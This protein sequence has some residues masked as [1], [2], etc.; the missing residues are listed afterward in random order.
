M[1][2][3]LLLIFPAMRMVVCAWGDITISD[4]ARSF[5]GLVFVG[6]RVG[7]F[8]FVLLSGR[9]LFMDKFLEIFF[10]SCLT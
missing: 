2:E 10:T 6:F 1:L 3:L 5:H 4:E 8:C 7:F 9:S